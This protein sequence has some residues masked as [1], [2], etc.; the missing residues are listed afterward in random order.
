MKQ[1][2]HSAF[3]GKARLARRYLVRHGYTPIPGS[4]VMLP[5]GT[6]SVPMAYGGVVHIAFATV[7][8]TACRCVAI[9]PAHPA[10]VVKTNG[11]GNGAGVGD[12]AGHGN[13]NGNG[14]GHPRPDRAE[15]VRA[16][17]TLLNFMTT[18]E[19]NSVSRGS[20]ELQLHI[21]AR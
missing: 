5:D 2:C 10:P 16:L 18:A 13:G 7:T 14:V 8:Q 1:V 4:G 12:S 19:S 20:E 11:V 21:A 6:V 15:V 3:R 17:D 9:L